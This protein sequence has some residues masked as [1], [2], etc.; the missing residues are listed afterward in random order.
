MT[1][2]SPRQRLEAQKTPPPAVQFPANNREFMDAIHG[3]NLGAAKPFVTSFNGNPKTAP[4]NDWAG[5]PYH[6]GQTVID[7][8]PKNRY[9]TLAVY[10]QVRGELRRTE[11]G[12]SAVCGVM[13]DD[14]GTKA[15]PLSRLDS[16]PPSFV[17]ETSAGNH[18]ATYLF[19]VPQTD[20]GA[21]KALNA[22]LIAANL[23]DK[24]AKSP[25]T[26]W[27]RLP[28]ATNE[29]YSPAFTCRL[30]EWHPERRYTPEQI[31]LGLGLD[32][33]RTAEP[34]SRSGELLDMWQMVQSDTQPNWDNVPA[35]FAAIKA[36]CEAIRW[37]TE[38]QGEVEEPYWRGVVGV[39]KHC[40][41]S[42]TLIHAI[43]EGHA[44]YD[45]GKTERKAQG[46]TTGPTTCEYFESFKADA[47]KRCPS[48]GRFK[49]PIALG[50]VQH[51]GGAIVGQVYGVVRPNRN[52][53]RATL[54]DWKVTQD[55]AKVRPHSTTENVAALADLLG[56]GIRYNVM[57][58]KAEITI[59]GLKTERDDHDTAALARFGDGAV[60]AG[61]QREGMKEL[62]DAVAGT[63]PHHPVLGWIEAT[64][65]DTI[66]RGQLFHESFV[67]VDIRHAKLRASLLDAWM[68]QGIGALLE[69]DGV[70]AQGIL[71]INGPQ[72]VNKTR[73][74]ANLCPVPGAV[75][76]GIHLDPLDKDSVF[77]ATSAWVT[78]LGEIDSTFRK[79]D[80]S[81]MKAFT[82]RRVDVLRRPYAKTDNTYR[83]RTIFAGTVN[84]TGYLA[85]STGDRRFWTLEVTHCTLL[86]ADVMQQIWAEYMARY[87]A[88]ER[89]HLTPETKA[90][91]NVS[92]ADHRVI[93]PLR[94]RI[95]TSFNWS[96][97]EGENWQAQTGVMWLT[98]T[99]VCLRV[100]IPHPSKTEATRAGAIVSDLNNRVSRKSNGAKLLALPPL[101]GSQP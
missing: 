90:A 38:N 77:Q 2:L 25:A 75:L 81:A 63:N 50:Q 40:E 71:V 39:A 33:P 56:I 52:Q 29:K 95:Q 88:G 30:V 36:G 85:D 53:L 13:L 96:K 97:V 45:Y 66:S 54:P 67:L 34:E 16:C 57:S 23:C 7:G 44:D 48:Q 49:S 82:D 99:D 11:E 26:R 73:K 61:L 18:Q 3:G 46:W 62:V 43:S 5:E 79:A 76:T 100:G 27:G 22:S 42:G 35:D 69:T 86:P 15:L 20:K 93:E 92:N 10:E 80:V 8:A 41:G 60:R 58:R 14:I 12:C 19:I 47:C 64:P 28:Y 70:S 91:L 98:A 89:W 84:G 51:G 32:L 59:P 17:I 21:M 6:H 24:G 74:I 101:G 68:L 65:W 37:A 31:A 55:G 4:G 78:E 83:R 72:G 9:L 1:T 94:E 87:L